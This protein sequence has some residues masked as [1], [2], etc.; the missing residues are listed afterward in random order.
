VTNDRIKLSGIE[1]FAHHGV[2]PEEKER[3]QRFLID[4]ELV[5]SLSGPGRS[6]RLEDTIDYSQLATA[7]HDL[8]ATQRF[9]LIEAVAEAVADLV[10]GLPVDEVMVRVS[11]P[12]APLA[13]RVGGLSVTIHRTRA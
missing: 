7:V 2:Y 4:V 11:K 10:L 8:V 9:N 3:G 12:D 13:V 5:V 6:D 1:V